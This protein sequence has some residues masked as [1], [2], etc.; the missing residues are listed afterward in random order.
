MRDPAV[1]DETSPRFFAALR[2][3]VW[4]AMSR[5]FAKALASLPW[6]LSV[7][8]AA[9]A[10]KSTTL[11]RPGIDVRAAYS[12]LKPVARFK[13]GENADWVAI[14]RHSVWVT[15]KG[16]NTLVRID[17]RT[18]TV[19]DT[20][21]L[22]GDACSGF[23]FGFGSVWVPLCGKPNVLLRVDLATHH[24]TTLS[25][26]P[27]GAEG[28]IAASDDSIWLVS[29]DAGTLNRIDPKTNRVRQ[30]VAIA[31]GS[32]NPIFDHG[33]IWVTSFKGDLVTA[34][35]ARTG[36]IVA[37]IAVGR[38]P[39]FLTAGGGLVWTLNQGDGTITRVDE[40]T[41]KAVATIDAK[42]PGHGGDI[43]YGNGRVWATLSGTPLTRIEV[44]TNQVV[45]QWT[46]PGGDALRVGL[47]SIW[48]T[49]YDKG[50][51]LRI[52]LGQVMGR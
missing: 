26:G 25:P 5:R 40:V 11:P 37:S 29:D 49:D 45:R 44:R 35:N 20:I 38:G 23:A 14:E 28:G 46:G 9:G 39:R 30:R 24:A 41:L 12:S 7:Y 22:P 2:M 33:R 10:Q 52:P 8:V 36:A 34:V 42:L 32:Y 21:A 43:A 17:P 47:G 6:L 4:H 1:E 18:N 15:S 3:V 27:A 13:V 51:L 19:A 50:L 48:I 16:P 31:P